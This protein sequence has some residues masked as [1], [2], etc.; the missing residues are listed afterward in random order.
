ML[1]FRGPESGSDYQSSSEMPISLF[2][3]NRGFLTSFDLSLPLHNGI[4]RQKKRYGASVY[5]MKDRLQNEIDVKRTIYNI[6]FPNNSPLIFIKD[7]IL[8]WSRSISLNSL[9]R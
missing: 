8:E 9:Q 1:L 2:Y 6:F 3:R 5:S 4:N 7:T